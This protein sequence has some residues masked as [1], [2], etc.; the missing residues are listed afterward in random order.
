MRSLS[1]AAIL[2]LVASLALAGASGDAPGPQAEM[3]GEM[4]TAVFAGGCFWC[5]EADFEK[6]DGVKEAV[7]G[8]AGG[9]IANPTYE[10]VTYGDTGHLESV[11]VAYD[12]S[13][14]TYR[15]LV[16]FFFRHIDPLDPDG[17]FCD[18]GS[19]YRTAIFAETLDER[20]IA[21]DEKEKASEQLGEQ[22]VTAVVDR[23]P[24]YLAEDYHQDYYKKNRLKY[25]IYR[26]GCRR[27]ARVRQL[28]GDDSGAPH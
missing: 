5:V 12:P 16:H 8:Y 7:S 28:W 1:L 17:Q 13:V 21:L 11:E 22:V 23:G 25:S 20:L 4:R 2:A 6:L 3:T 9:V 14:I 19:S 27:D 10:Q 18:K 26:T 15:Q 24:F